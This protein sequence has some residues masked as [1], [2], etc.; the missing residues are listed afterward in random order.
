MIGFN[1]LKMIFNR[2]GK[3][4]E[5]LAVGL[6]SVAFPHPVEAHQNI[7]SNGLGISWQID[8]G[9][10]VQ[11]NQESLASQGGSGIEAILVTDSS[12]DAVINRILPGIIVLRTQISQEGW[13]IG[14]AMVIHW[15]FVNTRRI[16][17]SILELAPVNGV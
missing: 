4:L 11:E 6:E 5:I 17:V 2:F 8:N 9:P 16:P 7:F 14:N 12:P 3:V 10:R 1:R 15:Q 13:Q